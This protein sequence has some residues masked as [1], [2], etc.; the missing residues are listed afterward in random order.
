MKLVEKYA[1]YSSQIKTIAESYQSL[2]FMPKFFDFVVSVMSLHHFLPSEKTSL[3]R[4]L[5][6]SL[7]PGGVFV[8]GDY[9]V[10]TEEEKRLLAEYLQQKKSHSLLNDVQYHIDIPFSEE[11]QLKALKNA[12]FS[13]VDVIFRTERSNVIVAKTDIA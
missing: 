2:E 8:E 6:H 7:V 9:I 11:T 10:T 5:S 4:K 3:Y 13:K 1:T 12:G